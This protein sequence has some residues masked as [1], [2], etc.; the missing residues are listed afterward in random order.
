MD[1]M[2]FETY[3]LPELTIAEAQEQAFKRGDILVIDEIPILKQNYERNLARLEFIVD[4]VAFKGLTYKEAS[5]LWD[6]GIT[7]L[8]TSVET[9]N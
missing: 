6:D 4:A 9:I 7:T 8:H 1:D 3:F 2:Y 5:A